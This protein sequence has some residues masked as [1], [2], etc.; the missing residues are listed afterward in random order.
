M[1]VSGKV[2]WFNG[3]PS[4]VH[5]DYMVRASE[6]ENLPMVEPVYPLTAGLSAR[7]LRKSIEAALPRLPQFPEW[8][9]ETLARQQSFDSVRD[10]FLALHDPRD[11]ADLDPQAPSRRRL[12]YDE[13]LA[14]QLSL[15]LVR[16]RAAQ[17]RRRSRQGHRQAERPRDRPP[18]PFR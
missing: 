6:A 17:G 8:L 4:M 2:D 9:D 3:R 15:S 18:C 12:A 16:Q 14:G 10:S 11:A 5:P 13:F 7:I 1:I